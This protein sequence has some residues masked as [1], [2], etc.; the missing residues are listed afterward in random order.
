MDLRKNNRIS[1]YDY[2]QNG[3]YFVTVCTYE[4]QRILSQIVGDGSPVLLPLGKILE[5]MIRRIPEKYP[6]VT[7]DKC[8]IMPDHIHMLLRIDQF[9]GTGN[10]SPGVHF[11]VVQTL[12]TP[13]NLHR[14]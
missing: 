10:P 11:P 7:V 12:R 8:V 6:C 13:R 5:E 9:F 2:S 1:E 3:A 14:N 4:R